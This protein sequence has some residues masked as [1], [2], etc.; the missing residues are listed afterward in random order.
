MIR[1]GDPS[2]VVSCVDGLLADRSPTAGIPLG[3]FLR[4]I[5]D[6]ILAAGASDGDL[7]ELTHSH[8]GARLMSVE[9]ARPV[10]L[11]VGELVVNAVAYAHPTGVWGRVDVSSRAGAPAGA[12]CIEVADDGVGLPELFDPL[13]DGGAGLTAVRSMAEQLGAKL[14][15]RDDGV[16]LSV[17]LDVPGPVGLAPEP[18][19]H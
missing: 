18:R 6:R 2:R 17:R 1:R 3:P 12:V 16:G 11:I 19:K 4:A 7:T 8:A 9:R 5:T 13:V 14:H 10:G 15:F